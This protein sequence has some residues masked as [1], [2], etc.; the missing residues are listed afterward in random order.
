MVLK[1]EIV[2]LAS[3]GFYHASAGLRGWEIVLH[4]I[5]KTINIFVKKVL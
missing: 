4:P 3:Q 1:M 5:F 2:N